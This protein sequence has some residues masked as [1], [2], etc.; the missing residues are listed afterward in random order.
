LVV[1][2]AGSTFHCFAAA[3][4]SIARAAAP[5]PRMIG[6]MSWMLVLPPVVWSLKTGSMYTS[7]AGAICTRTRSNGRSSSSATSIGRPV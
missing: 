1:H 6:Y 3:A 4:I 5:A 2:E 7:S